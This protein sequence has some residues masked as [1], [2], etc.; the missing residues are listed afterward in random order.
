MLG[1]DILLGD[2]KIA[3]QSRLAGQKIVIMRINP[4]GTDVVTD[5]EELA[6]RVIERAKV[7]LIG[8]SSGPVGA[9]LQRAAQSAP[10][11]QSPPRD[12]AQFRLPNPQ[13]TGFVLLGKHAFQHFGRIPQPGNVVQTRIG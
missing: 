2:G 11:N 4:L 6:A 9:A 7:H 12:L 1:R 8:Q 13:R 10:P 3:R 5:M